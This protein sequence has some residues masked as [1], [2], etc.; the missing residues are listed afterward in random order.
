[1]RL[2][3]APRARSETSSNPRGRGRRRQVPLRDAGGSTSKWLKRTWAGVTR[4]SGGG[5]GASRVGLPGERREHPRRRPPS[6][7]HGVG[8]RAVAGGHVPGQPDAGGTEGRECPPV[9]RRRARPAGE[10]GRRAWPSASS[11]RSQGIVLV[12][13]VTTGRRRPLASGSP[14]LDL[15]D[16][17]GRDASGAEDPDRLPVRQQLHSL[18][19]A[20]SISGRDGRHLL[21]SAPV[22]DRHRGG[23]AAECRSRAVDGGVA[24]PHHHDVARERGVAPSRFA[25]SRKRM[26]WT[27]PGRSAPGTSSPVRR[28]RPAARITASLA[29]GESRDSRPASRKVPVRAFTPS[30]RIAVEVAIEHLVG[31]SVGGDAGAEHA[32]EARLPLDDR[33]V[34]PGQ[35]EREGGA[36]PGWSAA[37]HGDPARERPRGRGRTDAPATWSPIQ[38]S[39]PRMSTAPS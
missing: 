2:L 34:V 18:G 21:A 20:S 39:S 13:A 37:H 33:H 3:A 9:A 17:D 1:M 19:Q 29:G 27:T 23:A 7:A 38:R 5:R 32:A 12:R 4:S 8:H 28:G 10:T 16:L 36:Q 22:D 15:G 25:A 11:T 30:A 14:E 31:Q 35:R 26:P 6:A 24:A